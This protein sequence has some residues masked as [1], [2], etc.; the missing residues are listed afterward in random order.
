MRERPSIKGYDTEAGIAEA[1]AALER[2]RPAGGDL[3]AETRRRLREARKREARFQRRGSPVE[4][5]S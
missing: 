5:L 2:R 1:R 3:T 4:P